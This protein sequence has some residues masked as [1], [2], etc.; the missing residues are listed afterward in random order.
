ML[1]AG[2]D[3][4]TT[5]HQRAVNHPAVLGRQIVA[6]NA[7]FKHIKPVALSRQ[8]LALTGELETLAQAKKGSR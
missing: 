1:T 3:T 7:A 8:I 2:Y 6:M 5:P 4:A